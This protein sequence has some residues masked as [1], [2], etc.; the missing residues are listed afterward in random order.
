MTFLSALWY[1][2]IWENWAVSVYIHD[3]VTVKNKHY[4]NIMENKLC[5]LSLLFWIRL[6]WE[7]LGVKSL[8]QTLSCW[9]CCPLKAFYLVDFANN[10][11]A[12]LLLII[13]EVSLCTLKIKHSSLMWRVND[14]DNHIGIIEMSLMF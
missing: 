12:E 2:R 11:F 10:P 7:L 13:Q 3:F 9:H 6:R 5:L 1:L 4:R 14:K 8:K